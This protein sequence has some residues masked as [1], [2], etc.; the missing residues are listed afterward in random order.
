MNDSL[1]IRRLM[2][3]TTYVRGDIFDVPK[4]RHLS[5]AM[6]TDLL[7]YEA[8]LYRPERLNRHR[9]LALRQPQARVTRINLV[10]GVTGIDSRDRGLG[11]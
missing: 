2:V 1:T 5:E 11:V 4:R 8:A 10:G 7:S 3:G 6:K 9:N